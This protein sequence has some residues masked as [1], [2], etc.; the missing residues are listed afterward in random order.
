MLA[1]N[2]SLPAKQA[3]CPYVTLCGIE[4]HIRLFLSK[5]LWRKIPVLGCEYSLEPKAE[6]MLTRQFQGTFDQNY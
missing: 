1:V 6:A 5:Q 4:N 2:A 3:Q